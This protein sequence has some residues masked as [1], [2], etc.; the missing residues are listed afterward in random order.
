M[1]KLLRD[2]TPSCIRQAIFVYGYIST[3][4]ALAIICAPK[5]NAFWG[6][7]DDDDDFRGYDDFS[8]S[9]DDVSNDDDDGLWSVGTISF[10]GV[11]VAVAVIVVLCGCKMG[12]DSAESGDACSPYV[13]ASLWI[14]FHLFDIMSDWGFYGYDCPDTLKTP[15]LVFCIFGTILT[16]ISIALH[17][18]VDETDSDDN[19]KL[20]MGMGLFLLED[21][22]Q[23]VIVLHSIMTPSLYADDHYNDGDDYNDEPQESF[24]DRA[25]GTVGIISLVF[26]SIGLLVG[27]GKTFIWC[28]RMQW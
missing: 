11:S 17:I 12:Y 18:Q 3:A 7:D 26:S 28:A 24:Q 16:L 4:L 13:M 1:L 27:F 5:T 25:L 23:F 22:P 21:L 20:F 10:F 14:A 15:S 6:D 8:Y 9:N 2:Q 19:S